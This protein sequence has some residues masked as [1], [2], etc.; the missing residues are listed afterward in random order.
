MI[1]DFSKVLRLILSYSV[2]TFTMSQT[3]VISMETC[4]Y[5]DCNFDCPDVIIWIRRL[6]CAEDHCGNVQWFAVFVLNS[7]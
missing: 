3:V 2:Y 7:S 1:S 4:R 6:V 5:D